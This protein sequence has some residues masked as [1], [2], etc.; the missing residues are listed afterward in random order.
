M[1]RVYWNESV[2][3]K[4][5]VEEARRTSRARRGVWERALDHHRSVSIWLKYAGMD[6]RTG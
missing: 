6:M 1:R 3:V 5:A 4:Y 2:W